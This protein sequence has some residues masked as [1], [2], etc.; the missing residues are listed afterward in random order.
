MSEPVKTTEHWFADD[1]AVVLTNVRDTLES[2]DPRMR[3]GA[4]RHLAAGVD[5]IARRVLFE[6]LAWV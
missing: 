2:P 3:V 5:V 1:L 6:A 4:A